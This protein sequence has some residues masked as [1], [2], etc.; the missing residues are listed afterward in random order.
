MK[1]GGEWNGLP[2]D[3]LKKLKCIWLSQS[4]AWPMMG[5]FEG[6]FFRITNSEAGIAADYW[7]E[8][9]IIEL[10]MI[11]GIRVG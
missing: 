1:R 8:G 4:S 11:V 7:N 3:R 9:G 2:C 10:A 5:A 6:N